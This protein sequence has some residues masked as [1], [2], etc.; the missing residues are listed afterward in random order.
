LTRQQKLPFGRGLLSGGP[1]DLDAA[2]IVPV[3]AADKTLLGCDGAE[4]GT[5]IGANPL[6]AKSRSGRLRPEKG[7]F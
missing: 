7:S 6:A 4:R 1:V 3:R 5:A 2:G